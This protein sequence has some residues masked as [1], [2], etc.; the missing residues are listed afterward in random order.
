MLLFIGGSALKRIFAN[1]FFVLQAKLLQRKSLNK[2]FSKL[3]FAF[4]SVSQ[5]P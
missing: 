2:E 3:N 4:L 5:T 1:V